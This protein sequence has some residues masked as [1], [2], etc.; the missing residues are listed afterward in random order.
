M[1]FKNTKAAILKKKNL[2]EIINIDLDKPDSNQVLV[3]IYYS[4]ICA[5]QY[6]E[7][8]AMR[9]KDKWL[10][11]ML[12]HEGVGIIKKIGKGVKKFK[13]GDKVILSWIKSKKGKD[14]SGSFLHNKKKINYGPIT[15]FANYS[16]ISANRVYKIPKNIKF[17]DAT[18]YGCSI[19]TGMGIVINEAKPKKKDICLVAGLGGI[20]IFSLIALKALGIEIILGVDNNQ[21]RLDFLKKLGFKNLVNITDKNY[22]EKINKITQ[23]KKL[24]YVFESSGKTSSIQ[25]F[26][27]L[28]NMRYG[29]LYFSSHPKK[30]DKIFLNPYELICGKKIFGS[31]G[32]GSDLDKDLKI[33]SKLLKRSKIR[34]DKLYG[35]YSFN[36]IK[37]LIKNFPKLNRPRTIVKM[38]H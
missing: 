14:A 13:I 28:L 3:K 30:G 22:L 34:L 23:N 26:F 11:H 8:R 20:G 36:N 25:K 16:L 35:V 17:R 21:S 38:Q 9:G 12:G 29:K 6:M 37:K 4:G 10:P 19:P 7:Y 27:D 24:D 2:L 5:S 32:G 15:T 18:L 33:F 31:W 1:I